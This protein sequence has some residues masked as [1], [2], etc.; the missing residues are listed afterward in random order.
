MQHSE[1]CYNVFSNRCDFKTT[2]RIIYKT[3][4]DSY[5]CYRRP[6]DTKQ[7]E[8]NR[9]NPFSK[10]SHNRIYSIIFLDSSFELS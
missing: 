6:T 3:Q 7:G 8:L 4:Y 5:L 1:T 2:R 10:V 9:H